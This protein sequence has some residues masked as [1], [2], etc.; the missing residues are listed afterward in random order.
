MAAEYNGI[1]AGAF[2]SI[3]YIASASGTLQAKL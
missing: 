3:L 1:E 2:M